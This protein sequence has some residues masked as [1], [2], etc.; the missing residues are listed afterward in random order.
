MTTFRRLDTKYLRELESKLC[1]GQYYYWQN[2]GGRRASTADYALV[3][4]DSGKPLVMDFVRLGMNG[5]QPRFRSLDKPVIMRSI[6]EFKAK[7]VEQHDDPA[8]W[9]LHPDAHLIAISREL[10]TEVIRLRE[11]EERVRQFQ[12]DAHSQMLLE[13]AYAPV[14]DFKCLEY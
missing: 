13:H 5:A 4:S 2:L 11:L 1:P 7:A 9:P 10:L 12:T 8:G 3:S 14:L 6:T